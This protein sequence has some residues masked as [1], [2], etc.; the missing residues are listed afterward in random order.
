MTSQTSDQTPNVNQSA[1]HTA[2][3]SLWSLAW[4]RLR[5]DRVGFTSLLIVIAYLLLCLGAWVNLIGADWRDEIALP[6]APPTF[7][8]W[9]P[10][11]TEINTNKIGIA[12]DSSLEATD[13]ASDETDDSDPL[14]ALM[15]EAESNAG[16]YEQQQAPKLET[17]ILG[18]DGR[19]RDILQK[20]LKGTSVSVVVALFGSFCAILIGTLLGAIAGYFGKW[21][22]DIL[23]WFYSIF[24]SIPDMLLLLSFAVVFARGIDTLIIIFGLTS[25]TSIFRLMRAEFMKHKHREY[26]QA[27]DTIGAGQSRKM[28]LHILPNVSHILLVQFSILTVGMIKSEVVL[29]FLGFGVDITQTSWG[30]M[31]AEVPAELIQGYWWQ[32]VTVT[33][34]MSV[35]VTAFSLLTDSMRDALDPKVK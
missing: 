5:R 11:G 21:V 23:M 25:W 1:T 2:S 29:S 10:R 32:M 18:A 34:F 28:F 27:A 14:A 24:T 31:L 19:G 4:K 30:S 17:L 35:L 26:V 7:A 20:T 6:H 3:R 16:E 15:A 22:D 13:S 9:I 8:T 12:E 33:V